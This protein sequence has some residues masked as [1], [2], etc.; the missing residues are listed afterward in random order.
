MKYRTLGKTDLDVSVIGLG[1]WQFGGEWGKEYSQPEVDA[2][3]EKARETGINLIDT[4]ECYGDHL[5]EQFIG[6]A[7]E[8]DRDQW[9]L[10]TKFGHKFHDLYERTRHFKSEEVKQQLEDSLRSLRTDYID[11]YQ[12][13]SGVGEEF[14]NDKL[15]TMLDKQLKE[16][17]IRHIGLS[18]GK[19]DNIYQTRKSSEIGAESIQ[20]V[21]NRLDRTPEEEVFPSCEEQNL[22]VLARV[23]MA[24]GYLSGKYKPGATFAENDVRHRHDQ[25][26]TRRKL[27]TVAELEKHE[28]PQGVPMAQ[29]A[30]AWCLKHPAVT[31]VI[32]G[33]KNPDQVESNAKAADL[34]MVKTNH[35]QATV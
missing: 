32:P 1:T 3:F 10:A 22:G 6:K 25:E 14:D 31:C 5:S 12:L 26:E 34:E 30:L 29:W 35:P 11:L 33:C 27:A 7:I 15:W 17:K 9:V 13:H 20:V 18:I 28:V 2:I 19:N 16:G 8:K 4:A 23:P 24:S 21:Y